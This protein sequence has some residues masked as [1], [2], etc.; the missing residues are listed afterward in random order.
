MHTWV[1]RRS[2]A[3]QPQCEMHV[4]IIKLLNLN[5]SPIVSTSQSCEINFTTKAGAVNR[6][7]SLGF[8]TTTLLL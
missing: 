5:V 8:V 4:V 6:Q 7:Q 1:D 3:Q 2:T